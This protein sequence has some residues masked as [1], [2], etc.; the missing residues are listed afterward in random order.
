MKNIYSLIDFSRYNIDSIHF[1]KNV[2]NLK[3]FDKIQ[4]YG[5]IVFKRN[6]NYI[7]PVYTSTCDLHNIMIHFAV[8]EYFTDLDILLS[9]NKNMD[10]IYPE[11]DH[12]VLHNIIC[13]ARGHSK[14]EKEILSQFLKC[15]N[16]YIIESY[17]S[18]P[19]DFDILD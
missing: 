8:L 15:C 4:S 10:T 9:T 12:L 3:R 1:F 6:Y 2:E 14:K 18:C 19:V 17:D 13:S 7:Y 16:I 11:H 5:E